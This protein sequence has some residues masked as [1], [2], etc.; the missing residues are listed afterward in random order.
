MDD[1]EPSNVPSAA[2]KARSKVGCFIACGLIG[3]CL[4]L[5]IGWCAP[6]LVSKRYK[7]IGEQIIAKENGKT[8]ALA[9]NDFASEYGSFPDHE[10]AEA[11]KKN[12]L[13]TL[14][15]DGDT[16]N[17]YFRQLIA[18]GMAKSENPFSARTDYS[19]KRPDNYMKGDQ[20]LKLGEVG[21]GY[22]MNGTKALPADNLNRVIAVTPL[23]NGSVTGEFDPNPLD[24]MAVL[25][26][27]DTSVK[28]VRIRK[29]DR[30]VMLGGK[31]LL[32]N[33]ADTVWGTAITPVIKPPLGHQV[34]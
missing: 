33:G 23:R 30:Q 11:V 7:Q 18:A 27:L 22:I 24:G 32:E 12:T 9:L 26:L 6:S 25:V 4:V 21:F 2:E 28:M 5:V 16:A 31:K 15:L 13:T 20:A 29:E 3:L 8:M 19:R 17:H 10:T 14:D 1:S 34:Q